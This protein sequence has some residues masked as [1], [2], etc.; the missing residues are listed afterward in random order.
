MRDRSRAEVEQKLRSIKIPPDLATKAAAGAGLRGE[1]ARKFARDNKNLVNLTNNQ[2]SYLL[3]VNLPSYEAIVRRGT[4][5]YLTQ[6]EFNALVSFVYN[7]GRG[8]PGVRAAINSG[9]KRKAVRIIEEQVRSKGKVLRGLV[10]RRHD[11]AMLLLE[12]RY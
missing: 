8:W 2:Q 1:A 6:N 11:E 7:P 10:K 12:G 9:D 5:V 4:H 3:Q